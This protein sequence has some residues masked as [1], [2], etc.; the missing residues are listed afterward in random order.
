MAEGFPSL[1]LTDVVSI[2]VNIVACH[3]ILIAALLV[4]VGESIE[5]L[6]DLMKQLEP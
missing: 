1:S 6:V 4:G 3:S 5:E 2:F